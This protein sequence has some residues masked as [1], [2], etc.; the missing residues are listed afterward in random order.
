MTLM[1][2]AG[3]DGIYG[4]VN[5]GLNIRSVISKTMGMHFIGRRRELGY[6]EDMHRYADSKTCILYGRR[7]IGKSAL[8]DTFV[9]GRD[10]VVFRFGDISDYETREYMALVLGARMDYDLEPFEVYGDAFYTIKECTGKGSVVV[11][12]GLE[13]M[14]WNREF[15][16]SV[17]TMLEYNANH[18]IM[19][20][21]SIDEAYVEQVFDDP[22]SPLYRTE[23]G[24][25]ELKPMRLRDAMD[26][27]PGLSDEELLKMYM[28]VGGVPSYNEAMQG[29]RLKDAIKSCFLGPGAPLADAADKA[30]TVTPH[31]M[32]S[33]ILACIAD[34]IDTQTDIARSIGVT[35]AL[36]KRYLDVMESRG[37]VEVVNTMF[38]ARKRMAYRIREPIQAFRYMVLRK[39][40]HRLADCDV[41]A[42]YR[43]MEPLLED[44]FKQRFVQYSCEF[45]RNTYRIKE[46]GVWYDAEGNGVD[47]AATAYGTMNAEVPMAVR[48][49]FRR[50]PVGRKTLDSLLESTAVLEDPEMRYVIIAPSGFDREFWTEAREE[51][52]ILLDMDSIMG[53]R[54]IRPL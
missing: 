28:I 16:D 21:L 13:N 9:K 5:P 24:R 35:K 50:R 40:A 30:L 37:I 29:V 47:I 46:I 34:G 45:L 4:T 19:T 1:H 3:I 11:I 53:R 2:T 42:T 33:G 20:I 18:G 6:L 41:D 38:G 31:G 51:G 14:C 25:M 23:A 36:C 7:G 48:C 54:P 43:E 22:E 15:L 8:I 49:R 27:H 44:Y 32:N 12:D 52:R 17:D 39:L 10:A 26:F